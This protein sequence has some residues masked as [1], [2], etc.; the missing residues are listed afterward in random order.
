MID[1]P[2]T[3]TDKLREDFRLACQWRER[4]RAALLEIQRVSQG[5][6]TKHELILEIHRIALEVYR[7]EQ[8]E[9]RERAKT[10]TVADVERQRV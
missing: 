10:Q 2:M 5:K 9:I 4:F 7:S 6:I 3:E 1:D 8:A